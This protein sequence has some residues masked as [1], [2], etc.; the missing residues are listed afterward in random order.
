[1]D[2]WIDRVKFASLADWFAY[3]HVLQTQYSLFTSSGL[4]KLLML[5]PTPPPR[6]LPLL[7]P[8][9]R[10]LFFFFFF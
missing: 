9:C 2:G 5:E 3:W 8:P 7:L 1:M 6:L 10:Q 4:I